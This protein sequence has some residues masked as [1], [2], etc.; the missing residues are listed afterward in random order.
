MK[1]PTAVT[2]LVACLVVALPPAARAQASRNTLTPA[3]RAAGWRLL[4]DGKTTTGWRGWKMDT[5]PSGW[6]VV[7]G[8]LTR[9]RRAADII[10]TEK[11]KN[12]EL[13]LEWKIAPN[14][15]SGIFYRASEDDDAI[16]WS[17][18]EM[19]VLDDAG[20]P[21]GQ[22]RLTAAGS[23]YGLHPSPAG[24]VQPA[25]QWNQVRLIV[26]GNHVEHW[27]NG[28]KVVEY[29]LGSADWEARVKAS[30]FA[31][32]PHYGRNPE[33]Y[34]GLQEHDSWV[35]YRNIKIRVLP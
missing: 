29:E 14:G 32:H 23:D 1:Q 3:E 5:L 8:A 2:L 16:Y 19:Q 35:A 21:D 30:K 4:F 22:S 20:H 17:A 10:T 13:S 34:I 7:D 26:N 12:F 6:Q 28:V 27:L 31:P 18:P 11:F 33:G 24:V 25:G 9:V 15:N